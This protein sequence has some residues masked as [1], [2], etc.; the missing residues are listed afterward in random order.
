MKIY[1]QSLVGLC[2]VLG[3]SAC[4]DENVREVVDSL[5]EDPSYADDVVWPTQAGTGCPSWQRGETVTITESMQLPANCTF[6]QVT[7]HINASD[8]DFDCNS[9]VFN[10]LREQ[11]RHEYGDSYS[12]SETAPQGVGFLVRGSETAA[13]PLQNITIRN[14]QITN[15]IHGV[16]V[17]LTLSSETTAGL[18]AGTV[19]EDT[20]RALAPANVQ[21]LDSII[22]DTHGSGAYI[23]SY[24]TGFQLLRSSIKGAGGPGLYLDSGSR[25]AVIQNAVF[26]GNG[27]SSYNSETYSREARRSD[28]AKREAIAIDASTRHQVLNSTFRSNG[29]G[30]VYLYKNCWEDAESDTTEIPRTEGANFNRIEGNRFVN[31]TTGVWLAERADRDL[32][33]F[34]CGDPVIY[35]DDGEKYYRDIARENSVTD[36]RFEQL[37]TGVRVM[38][39]AN[40]IQNN[41]FVSSE[42]LDIDIGSEIREK[43]ADPV[44]GTVVDGNTLS[45]TDGI[46]Y[47]YGAQ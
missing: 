41:T 1:N 4:D 15:Y 13:S 3:L 10:G 18:R 12:P 42:E 5:Y 23:A 14:C 24:V 44:T 46:R 33:D 39:D 40:T 22:I 2:L 43:I 27:F 28:L 26:E 35:E 47:R 36:N 21:V 30:G 29:D 38:D 34:D 32:A 20:L 7:V 19:N 37:H 45:K 16:D 6:E 31:E 25:S 8:V 17:S 11:K 9:A